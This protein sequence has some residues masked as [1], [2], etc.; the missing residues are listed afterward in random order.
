[1]DENK[2]FDKQLDAT[3]DALSKAI[4]GDAYDCTRVWEAWSVGTMSEDDFEPITED[5]DRV[6]EIAMAVLDALNITDI[7]AILKML[8][9]AVDTGDAL[10]PRNIRSMLDDA[11]VKAGCKIETLLGEK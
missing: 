8:S 11:L 7:T 9:A 2:Y 1:M 4:G 10:I 3:C 6:N 5:I